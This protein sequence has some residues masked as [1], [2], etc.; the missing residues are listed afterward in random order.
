MFALRR[1]IRF[2][3]TWCRPGRRRWSPEGAGAGGATLRLRAVAIERRAWPENGEVGE[4]RW[5]ELEL[6]IVAD[7]GIVGVPNAGKSTLLSVIS[8]AAPKIAEYPFTTIV[9]NLGV[10]DVNHVQI[11]FADIPGLLE[12]AHDGVGLGLDFLRHIERSRIL[13]HLLDGA[14]PDP[15]GDYEVINQEMNLFNP[16]LANRPQLI[17]LNKIDLP[18]AQEVWPRLQEKLAETGNP[19]FAIS[20]VTEENVQQLLY[21]VKSI[22]DELPAPVETETADALPTLSPEQD[23]HAFSVDHLEDDLWQVKGIAIE[24]TAQM[25]NWDYY[26]SGLRFQRIL[27]AMGISDSLRQ[28]GVQDGDRVQIGGG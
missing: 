14:S 10:A 28:K 1:A 27:S 11:V 12:G 20:A 6:K 15:L 13:V 9:P 18:Q 26:E 4:E 22:L 24:R 8:D 3:P 5:L 25:T 23:E 17:V 7:A 16:M 21:K 19:L 2:W